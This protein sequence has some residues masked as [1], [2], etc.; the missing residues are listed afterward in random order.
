MTIAYSTAGVPL[1]TNVFGQ[2]AYGKAVAVGPNGNIYV[3]GYYYNQVWETSCGYTSGS[4]D[5]FA[6]LAYSS[7]GVPLWTNFYNGPA[8]GNEIPQTRQA[9]AIDGDGGVYVTGASAGGY[10]PGYAFDFATVKYSV[11]DPPVIVEEPKS[12][13]VIIGGSLSPSVSAVGAALSYQWLFNGNPVAGGSSNILSLTHVGL[14]QPGFY[15]VAVTNASGSVSS[16]SAQL[17]VLPT[18]GSAIDGLQVGALSGPR[19]NTLRMWGITGNAYI[20]Q[21]ATNLSG[22][23]W[24]DLSTDAP[25]ANGEWTVR[26]NAPT[27]QQRFYRVLRP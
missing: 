2:D 16:T 19:T 13:S 6:T 11:I 23:M 8:N 27:N 9:I 20:V 15:R 3:A 18:N 24:F 7:S 26:D 12:Q 17:V 22:S 5:D 10:Y 21:F 1:W 14:A 25:A 4:A